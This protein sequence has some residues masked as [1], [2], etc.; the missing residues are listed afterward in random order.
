MPLSTP[1]NPYFSNMKHSK[2]KF[3]ATLACCDVW[4]KVK[5]HDKMQIKNTIAAM[6]MKVILHDVLFK[7]A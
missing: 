5:E 6:N 7:R 3:S 2:M 1:G 4:V